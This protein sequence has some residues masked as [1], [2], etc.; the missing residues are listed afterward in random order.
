[1]SDGAPVIY[2]VDDDPSVRKSLARLVKAAGHRA[3]T[4]ASANGF[5]ESPRED[6]PGCLVLDVHLPGLSGLDLQEAL[7]VSGRPLPI[8]FITGLGDIPTS[9]KAMK[10]GAVDFLPKPFEGRVL[11]AAIAH[12]LELDAASR[13]QRDEAEALEAKLGTLSLRERQVFA[14]VTAGKLNKQAAMDLGITEKTIKV[15]RARLMQK[16]GASSL[17]ELVRLADRAGVRPPDPTSD[18]G[19][20]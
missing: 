7:S 10:G 2:I 5:L 17:A 11:L 16:L 18:P 12:A 13:K 19:A 15:H 8:I 9:V 1:M 14:L 20:S 4:F 6:G 3:Q